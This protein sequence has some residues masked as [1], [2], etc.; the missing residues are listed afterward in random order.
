MRVLYALPILRGGQGLVKRGRSGK[1]RDFL[2]EEARKKES[3][4]KKETCREKT[5]SG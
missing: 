4:W 5:S 1:G 2:L 3:W